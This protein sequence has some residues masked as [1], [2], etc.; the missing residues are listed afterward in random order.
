MTSLMEHRIAHLIS[1]HNLEYA[2]V[3]EFGQYHPLS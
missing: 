3:Q 2:G 1:L